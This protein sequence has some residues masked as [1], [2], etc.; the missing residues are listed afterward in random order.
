MIYRTV[1]PLVV[2]AVQV[3]E[4]QDVPTR[5]G[6]LHLKPGDWLIR[7]AHGNLMRCDDINFKCSYEAMDGRSELES[8]AEGKPCGC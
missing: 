1:K 6:L 8:F 2:D 5:G 3:G 7:D 4:S